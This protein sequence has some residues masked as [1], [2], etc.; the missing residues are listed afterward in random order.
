MGFGS[1]RPWRMVAIASVC[2]L[3]V[4]S[5]A[6]FAVFKL[7]GL[8]SQNAEVQLQP[9]ASGGPD[10]FMSSVA[11]T[12]APP[13]GTSS[14][15]AQTGGQVREAA[16]Q[17]SAPGLYGGTQQLGTCNANQMVAYLDHHPS[18]AQAW[19]QALNADPGL[20]WSGGTQVR[21]DQIDEYA[22]SLTSVLLRTDTRVTNHGYLNG[23]PTAFA[24]VL[25]AGTAVLVDQYGVPRARCACGNPLTAPTAVRGSP[26][27]VGPRWT[28]FHSSTLVVIAPSTTVVSNFVMV[29]INTSTT[30]VRPTGTSGASDAAPS[31][32]AASTVPDP[33][34]GVQLAPAATPAPVPS[35]GSQEQTAPTPT[36]APTENPT[37]GNPTAPNTPSTGRQPPITGSQ[38]PSTGSRP[39]NSGTTAPMPVMV[40]PNGGPVR[41][42]SSID[43]GGAHG[44]QIVGIQ[45]TGWGPDSAQGTGSETASNCIPDCA[46]GTQ[47]TKTETLSLSQPEN[48]MFTVM[49]Q[50]D[51]DGTQTWTYPSIWPVN[52]VG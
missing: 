3:L 20:R 45:W 7:T 11:S 26:V 43:L 37:S 15:S 31:N 5:G 49:T 39:P 50:K 4:G 9:A 30:F 40:T 33:V 2:A 34:P 22:H 42:P 25:Q 32:P 48:G 17:G 16:V 23:A 29:N 35:S 14:S 51:S 46:N 6:A 38:P 44:I 18:K 27:F 21:V 36:P 28:T 24:S 1:S 47:V 12:S 19:A 13:S 8:G 41:E 52:A 10:P